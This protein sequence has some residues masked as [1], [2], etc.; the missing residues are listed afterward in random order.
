MSHIKIGYCFI[1]TTNF[2]NNLLE[3]GW[4]KIT[5]FNN[6]LEKGWAKIT[7]F[8]NLLEKGWAK[9]REKVGPKSHL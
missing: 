9:I 2:I 6:L 7:P 4:A 5:P 8:N 1:F 3:K